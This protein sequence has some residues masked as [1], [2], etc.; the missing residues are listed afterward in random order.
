MNKHRLKRIENRLTPKRTLDLP[1]FLETEGEA[2]LF[3]DKLL[4]DLG[5]N[6]EDYPAYK[7]DPLAMSPEERL[8]PRDATFI[9]HF[10]GEDYAP[11]CYLYLKGYEDKPII[12][13]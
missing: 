4:L 6:P 2:L 5:L 13:P 9:S 8:V 1:I 10:K 11:D 12:L 3:S 7:G